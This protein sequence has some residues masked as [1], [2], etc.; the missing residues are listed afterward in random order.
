VAPNSTSAGERLGANQEQL[1]QFVNAH[2]DYFFVQEKAANLNHSAEIPGIG[3]L[4]RIIADMEVFFGLP[5]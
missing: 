4:D 2:P 3:D 1:H 5:R